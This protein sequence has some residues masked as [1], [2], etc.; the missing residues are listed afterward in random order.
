MN[1]TCIVIIILVLFVLFVLFVK[2]CNNKSFFEEDKIPKIIVQTYNKPIP[3]KV[4]EQFKKYAKGYKHVIFN[5]KDC[6]DFIQKHF[7]QA[8]SKFNSFGGPHKADLF[9]YCFLYIN[10]GIYLDIKTELIRNIDGLFNDNNF[11]TAITNGTNGRIYNGIIATKKNNK[12]L[13]DLINDIIKTPYDNSFKIMPNY[14]TFIRQFSKRLLK[15]TNQPLKSGLNNNNIYLFVERVSKL[16]PNRDKYGI[17]SY[18][19]DN[20][21]KIF[22]T[23][24]SDFGKIW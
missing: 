19:Y 22:N 18:I 13:L 6:R 16:C 21:K 5:D 11:T 8:I 15:E 24:F 2:V 4:Y 7:P 3:N 17:C 23:R 20:D 14:H 1:I 9:R 10:G 12:I